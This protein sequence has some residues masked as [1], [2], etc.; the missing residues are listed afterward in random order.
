MNKILS[1]RLSALATLVGLLVCPFAL[2]AQTDDRSDT[3]EHLNYRDQVVQIGQDVVLGTNESARVVVVIGGS[4]TIH[5]VVDEEVVV[6]GGD[7]EVD[8]NVDRDVVVVMGNARVGPKAKIG[9]QLVSIGGTN[10]IAEG[11]KVEREIVQVGTGGFLPQKFMKFKWLQDWLAQCVFKLRPLSF[12]V[13]W[14][15][16]IAGIFFVL[17][18]LIAVLFPH[19]VQCCVTQI[20]ERPATTLAVGIL[21]KVCIPILCLLLLVTVIGIAIIPFF[22]IGL[23]LI[24]LGGKVAVL[25]YLGA[26][27]GKMLGANTAQQPIVAFLIGIVF[28]TALYL[29]PV[30]GMLSFFV[31]SWWGLGTGVTALFVAIR[32]NRREATPV[33]PTAAPMPPTPPEQSGTTAPGNPRTPGDTSMPTSVPAAAPSSISMVTPGLSTTLPSAL[34]YPRAGFWERMGAGFLDMV[35]VSLGAALG[36]VAFLVMVAYFSGLWAWRGTTV[37][38]IVLNLHVVR[39]DGRPMNFLMALVRCLAAMFSAAILFLGFFWIAWD[40]EKQGWHDKIAGTVVVRVPRA[41]PLVCL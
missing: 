27:I 31:F 21:S 38:G 3:K 40:T 36:P 41:V 33:A 25:E 11:G 22:T 2:I 37:G 24:G 17:Y 19:P 5:G 35:L 23:A 16:W 32:A 15:W 29:V 9:G 30:I 7:V 12:A 34:A 8:G 13:G 26:R 18:L 6:I 1:L 20:S 28:L 39:L 10:H 14:V 4:A